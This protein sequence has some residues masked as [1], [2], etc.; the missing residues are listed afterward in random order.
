MVGL[1]PGPISDRIG[2]RGPR[3]AARPGRPRPGSILSDTVRGGQISGTDQMVRRL[4]AG[5]DL[6]SME[7][8]RHYLRISRQSLGLR[9][10]Q[11]IG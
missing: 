7:V 11:E 1:S 10:I 5:A 2:L 9:E 6:G 3:R 8:S 4:L